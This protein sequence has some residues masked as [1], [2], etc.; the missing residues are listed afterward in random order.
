[1]DDG[2]KIGKE[3]AGQKNRKN[4]AVG[5]FCTYYLQQKEKE[6]GRLATVCVV[7]LKAMVFFARDFF[8][9]MGLSK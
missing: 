9:I 2:D 7:S 5:S 3:S 6:E 1:M 4:R 8:R